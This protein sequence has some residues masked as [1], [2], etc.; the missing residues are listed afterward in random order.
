MLARIHPDDVS[1]CQRSGPAGDDSPAQTRL[2]TR[3]SATVWPC[4]QINWR[5]WT[6][7]TVCL[8][9]GGA[10]TVLHPSERALVVV[11]VAVPWTPP[12]VQGTA[13]RVVGL[14]LVRLTPAHRQQTPLFSF[15][16]QLCLLATQQT[17]Q[18]GFRL[19]LTPQSL[20]HAAATRHPTWPLARYQYYVC[21]DD[22]YILSAIQPFDVPKRNWLYD[23]LRGSGWMW[24]RHENSLW[25]I[26]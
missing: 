14:V 24:C 12:G 15:Y 22:S 13:E 26:S 19:R 6:S 21:W 5:R 25:D 2:L 16:W 8:S 10:V 4:D 20:P 11:V 7:P 23:I 3:C 9:V 17:Q 1:C 18:T